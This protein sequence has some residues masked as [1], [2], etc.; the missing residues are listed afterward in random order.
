MA[1]SAEFAP[2]RVWDAK[3]GTEIL[4]VE[5]EENV[6]FAAKPTRIV[7]G[8]MGY[9]AIRDAR[10][11]RVLFRLD[12]TSGGGGATGDTVRVATSRDGKWLA[13]AHDGRVEVWSLPLDRLVTILSGHSGPVTGL[14][15]TADG[16]PDCI[17]RPR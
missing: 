12:L 16:A 17:V 5:D 4:K 7:T 9:I 11:G 2:S 6:C 13:T 3:T 8:G 1:A 14:A 10:T 15:F